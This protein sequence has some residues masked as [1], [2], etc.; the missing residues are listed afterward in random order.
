MVEQTEEAVEAARTAGIITP[1]DNG[2]VETLLRLAERMDD[3][4]FPMID[5]RFDNVTESLYFKA[6]DSLGLTPAGRQKL[7]VKEQ[8]G[9]GKLAQLRAVNGGA[10]GKRAG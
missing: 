10:G 3:P 2:A 4:D 6:C 8:K 1:M 9:G 7:D 5:G